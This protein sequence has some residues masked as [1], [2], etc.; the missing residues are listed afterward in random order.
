MQG[1]GYTDR[2][3]HTDNLKL[4]SG[5]K[6][7]F[8]GSY[9]MPNHFKLRD[10]YRF[11][12][13]EITSFVDLSMTREVP[14]ATT[15]KQG[16]T[17]SIDAAELLAL[18]M[19]DIQVFSI[20]IEG[21]G[22][23]INEA[24]RE[25]ANYLAFRGYFRCV[26][27]AW[28]SAELRAVLNMETHGQL[29]NYVQHITVKLNSVED[30]FSNPGPLGHVEANHRRLLY[31]GA[32][33]TFCQTGNVF[34]TYLKR[35]GH[36]SLPPIYGVATDIYST[37]NTFKLY[38]FMGPSIIKVSKDDERHSHDYWLAHAQGAFFVL[39]T[40]LSFLTKGVRGIKPFSAPSFLKMPQ[41]KSL[42]KDALDDLRDEITSS[43][44]D[45][46]FVQKW[47]ELHAKAIDLFN[48]GTFDRKQ[49]ESDEYND[50]GIRYGFEVNN[51]E[52]KYTG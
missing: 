3:K 5:A 27:A 41:Q 31:G 19:Y 25:D 21:I 23:P 51:D 14:I 17:P 8:T 37:L 34:E 22:E 4:L 11:W 40:A 43:F 9:A 46:S 24:E 35:H 50:Y 44:V 28:L 26:Y 39:K 1:G 29:T 15:R 12:P 20:A 36:D 38:T 33:R 48:M 52:Q 16:F 45:L 32:S 10:D 2:I 6:Q 42:N 47:G 13:D 18:L 30:D 7:K 49:F